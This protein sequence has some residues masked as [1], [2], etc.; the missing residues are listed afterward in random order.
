MRLA[1]IL[2]ALSQS[3]LQHPL[4]LSL[5]HKFASAGRED[6]DVRML[7]IGKLAKLYCQGI[8]V[9]KEAVCFVCGKVKH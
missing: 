5:D 2:C 1:H 6:I 7:G 3:E 4:T 9:S 8:L